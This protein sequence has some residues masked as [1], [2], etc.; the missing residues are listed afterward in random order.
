MRLLQTIW[1]KLRRNER[2]PRTEIPIPSTTSKTLWQRRFT[3]L[4]ESEIAQGKMP[5][6]AGKIAAEQTIKEFS[7][8]F[9]DIEVPPW[10]PRS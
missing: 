8:A 4:S 5:S 6:E 10:I 9:E 3:Y 1:S 2:M 7:A